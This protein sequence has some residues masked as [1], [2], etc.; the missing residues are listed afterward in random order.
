MVASTM[1]KETCRAQSLI[2]MQKC[3]NSSQLWK[4][5]DCGRET[6]KCRD[7]A[8]C[9]KKKFNH[10]IYKIV[11]RE[12]GSPPSQDSNSFL[13]GIDLIVLYIQLKPHHIF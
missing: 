13:L 5:V 10:Q 1:P 2:K 6:V 12:F 7:R 3:P 8:D 11:D 9:Q 4:L